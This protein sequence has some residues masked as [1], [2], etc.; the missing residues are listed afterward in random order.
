MLYPVPDGQ[1]LVSALR[2]MLI[3]ENL[4]SLGAEKIQQCMLAAGSGVPEKL[5]KCSLESIAKDLALVG[6][7]KS[8]Y[9][10]ERLKHQLTRPLP[11]IDKALQELVD[12]DDWVLG[13]ELYVAL[14]RRELAPGLLTN[15]LAY[16]FIDGLVGERTPKPSFQSVWVLASQSG[17][18]LSLLKRTAPNPI[19]RAQVDR[20]NSAFTALGEGEILELAD[21]ARDLASLYLGGSLVQGAIVRQLSREDMR[22][23]ID[24][25][26][27]L[28]LDLERLGTK[29]PSRNQLADLSENISLLRRVYRGNETLVAKIDFVTVAHSVDPDAEPMPEL[30]TLLKIVQNLS[31]CINK[32]LRV[33]LDGIIEEYPLTLRNQEITARLSK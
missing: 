10:A 20:V 33:G 22:H 15:E 23:M 26:N 5:Q 3:L 16:R 27:H 13:I 28:A 6:R 29:G 25:A 32:V 21:E 17:G 24:C 8:E 2:A 18:L 12:T 1:G 19:L 11:P 30:R 31:R 7:G 9:V 14:K 4:P